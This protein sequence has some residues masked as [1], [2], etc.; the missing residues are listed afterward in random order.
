MY[1]KMHD[2]VHYTVASKNMNRPISCY[3]SFSTSIP[4]RDEIESKFSAA[5]DFYFAFPIISQ[6]LKAF[7]V[8]KN[9]Q[10]SSDLGLASIF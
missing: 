2:T 4:F 6:F 9:S 3:I 10:T 5:H 8:A 1:Y 7:I